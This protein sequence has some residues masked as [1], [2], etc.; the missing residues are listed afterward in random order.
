MCVCLKLL[1]NWLF[2][3]LKGNTKA[4][5]TERLLGEYTV[6]SGFPSTGPVTRKRSFMP[7]SHHDETIYTLFSFAI[8]TALGNINEQ[9]ARWRARWYRYATWL[10]KYGYCMPVVCFAVVVSSVPSL[11]LG[12]R[13]IYLP[14][15]SIVTSMAFEK[16]VLVP[17]KRTLNM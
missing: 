1:T 8:R 10:M 6:D 12:I 5:G 2:I 16:R 17:V 9:H 4:C 15:P 11:S 7:C 13:V 3:R 14:M